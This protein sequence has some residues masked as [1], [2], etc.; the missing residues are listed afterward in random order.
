MRFNDL[1]NEEIVKEAPAGLGATIKTAAKSMNPFSLSDRSQAQGQQVSNKAANDLYATY[2]KWVGQYNVP[3][4]AKSVLT[5]LKNS[6]YS[7]QAIGAAKAVLPAAPAKT[8]TTTPQTSQ[9]PT[10]EPQ[11]TTLDLDQLKAQR[12]GSATPANAATGYGARGVPGMDKTNEAATP[13]EILDKNVISKAFMA[14]VQT[15]KVPPKNLSPKAAAST[16]SQSNTTAPQTT[17]SAP[18]GQSFTDPAPQGE[19]DIQTVIQ[20]YRGLNPTDKQTVRAEMDKVDQTPAPSVDPINE[21]YSKFLGI[22]L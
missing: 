13:G 3:T 20:F 17:A 8:A 19:L 4:D 6:G 22:R 18:Q 1:F 14:A 21:G 15:Q 5:F 16:T 11:G 12:A 2:Y 10:P 9:T 7:T